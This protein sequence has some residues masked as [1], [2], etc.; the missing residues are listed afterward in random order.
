MFKMHLVKMLFV[1]TYSSSTSSL[2]YFDTVAADERI[3][4]R[5]ERRSEL[6]DG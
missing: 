3:L 6:R 1:D 2:L 5:E 4:T